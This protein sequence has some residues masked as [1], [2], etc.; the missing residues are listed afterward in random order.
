M[1]L[2]LMAAALDDVDVAAVPVSVRLYTAISAPPLLPLLLPP[3]MLALPPPP[4]WRPTPAVAIIDADD[5]VCK[6]VTVACCG[7]C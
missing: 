1:L 6:V 7:C 2:A 3:P 4:P 5:V